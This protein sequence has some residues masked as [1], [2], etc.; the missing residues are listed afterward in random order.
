MKTMDE[1]LRKTVSAQQRDWG[2]KPPFFLLV[3]SVLTIRPQVRWPPVWCSGGSY[4]CLA[5]YCLKHPHGKAQPTKDYLR[6]LME[7]L[8]EIDH[9]AC[10]YLKVATG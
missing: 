6:D 9:Y 8:H 5:I 1:Y 2:K 4:V 10:Q 3:Y 7:Q